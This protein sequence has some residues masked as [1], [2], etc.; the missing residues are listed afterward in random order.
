MRM[1]ECEGIPHLVLIDAKSGD[2]ITL[3]GRAAV[4]AG[5]DAFPFTPG[6]IAAAIQKR[7][8]KVLGEFKAWSALGSDVATLQAHEAVAIFIGNSENNAKH[9]AGPLVQ[10]S[11]ALG[12]RLKVFF[13]PYLVGDSASQAAFEAKFPSS[14][15][16][17]PQSTA[18]DLAKV[19]LHELC[20]AIASAS[21]PLL[22]DH[23]RNAGRRP[24]RA[25]AA[26]REPFLHRGHTAWCLQNCI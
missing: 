6:A 18:T 5:A 20:S 3:E 4:M 10:A 24:R 13:L 11:K 12:S 15:T 19:T 25:T 17:L 16:V 22:Q 9:V 2:V 21:N 8:S 7:S 14:W 23:L 1:Y 26:C